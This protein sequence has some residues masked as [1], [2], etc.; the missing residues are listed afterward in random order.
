M[1]SN[2]GSMLHW[3]FT[4]AIH[5]FGILMHFQHNLDTPV[6]VSNEP[7]TDLS[8]SLEDSRYMSGRT[9]WK[10]K[11]LH[12]IMI[13]FVNN[14]QGGMFHWVLANPDLD[15]GILVDFELG[16]DSTVLV[17]SDFQRIPQNASKLWFEPDKWLLVH[18]IQPNEPTPPKTLH[19]PPPTRAGALLWIRM[20]S[21]LL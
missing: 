19:V 9:A 13:C 20:A 16:L 1:K 17:S 3:V 7:K 2:Y 21:A 6:S 11:I 8:Y 18:R 4:V 12:Q 10:I 5:D 14:P 15:F